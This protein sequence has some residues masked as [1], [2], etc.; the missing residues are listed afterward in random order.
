MCHQMNIYLN[1]VLI[2]ITCTDM[3]T[4]VGNVLMNAMQ[5]R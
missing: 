2:F 5:M 1:K 4:R 3:M